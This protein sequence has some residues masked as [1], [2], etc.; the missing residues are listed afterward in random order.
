MT[1]QETVT[2]L[3]LAKNLYPRDKSPLFTDCFPGRSCNKT[4]G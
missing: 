2:L 1:L 4:G 3:Y